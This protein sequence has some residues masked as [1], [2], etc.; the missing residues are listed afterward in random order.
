MSDVIE[1]NKEITNANLD[2]F[3]SDGK[4]EENTISSSQRRLWIFDK[5]NPND[6]VIYN[7]P[8]S[9]KV[10][11]E[12][13]LERLKV[14]F[15]FLL[16]KHPL[17]RASIQENECDPFMILNNQFLPSY[18]QGTVSSLEEFLEIAKRELNEPFDLNQPPLIRLSVFQQSEDTYYI[19][20]IIHH[21]VAD[22][23]SISII[24]DT[25]FQ[26][27]LN[28]L[29]NQSLSEVDILPDMTYFQYIEQQKAI[30]FS[31]KYKSSE[32]FWISYL[33][34]APTKTDFPWDR[35][36]E[37]LQ[38]Y[39]GSLHNFYLSQHVADKVARFCSHHKVTPYTFFLSL[40]YVLLFRYSQQDK[41]VVATQSAN[42]NGRLYHATVGFFVNTLPICQ[43][44]KQEDKFLDFLAKIK[45][46]LIEAYK[47]QHVEF[48]RILELCKVDRTES[49]KPLCQTEFV[50]QNVR[51]CDEALKDWNI[52]NI[53]VPTD[54]AKYDLSFSVFPI[55]KTYQIVIEY[56]KELLECSTIKRL[57]NNFETLVRS[58]VSFPDIAIKDI[59][60]I[61]KSEKDQLARM[62]KGKQVDFSNRNLTS[63]YSDFA[64][65]D[66]SAI[67]SVFNKKSTSYSEILSSSS[68]LANFLDN[69]DVKK[70]DRVII[71]LS[72]GTLLLQAILACLMRLIIFIPINPDD[73]LENNLENILQGDPVVI[74]TDNNYFNKLKELNELDSFEIVNI[75]DVNITNTFSNF[76]K[77]IIRQP[78]DGDIA[79]IM[80]TSGSTG[81]PKGAM[82]T[83]KGMLNHLLSKIEILKLKKSDVVGQIAV[84]SFDVFIWQS[85]VGGLVGAKT[86]ILT[87]YQA[88]DPRPLFNA[89]KQYEITILETVPA[90][91][92]ILAS[93]ISRDISLVDSVQ[94]LR[95]LMSNGESISKKQVNIWFDYLPNINFINAYGPTEC[96]DDVLH[97]SITNKDQFQ[98]MFMPI[99]RPIQNV[100][101]YILDPQKRMLPIN[102]PGELYIAGI[103]VGKG[104]FR[105]Q[106]R[107]ASSFTPIPS[108]ISKYN[109][110]YKTGDIVKVDKEGI[111]HFI[112]RNDYEVKIRGARIDL[113]KIESI[114]M[115]HDNI[116]DAVVVKVNDSKSKLD[117]LVAYLIARDN[118][119]P[120]SKM[121]LIHCEKFLP[122]K[123]LPNGIVFLD[124]FP[125]LSN[126]KVDRK[127]LPEPH[128]ILSGA[129][130]DYV[131]PRNTREKQ[132]A[133][134][135]QSLLGVEK[136]G[137]DD[138]FFMLGGHSLL[139]IE[140]VREI[141]KILSEQIELAYFFENPSIRSL[142]DNLQ[143]FKKLEENRENE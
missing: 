50:M 69:K 137:I 125:V 120:T 23:W 25:L 48:D 68:V 37:N 58:I 1:H 95:C 85:L 31:D 29:N 117:M 136:I 91:L 103:P 123:M 66:P 24:V 100:E 83:H 128:T 46:N 139:A 67:F 115:M 78:E 16:Q 19:L 89:V 4:V 96:S 111:F 131:P 64:L 71:Y 73:K 82:V 44:I 106:V 138:N 118:P 21:I 45:R 74:L 77:E 33:K 72:R 17:L 101:L 84:Q 11:V 129:T 92:V 20:M 55:K 41:I 134:V 34:D 121:M 122:K 10:G 105:D 27:Y 88:W 119:A 36:V 126:G 142:L 39:D 127:S 49:H 5:C 40:Y 109:L 132:I 28:L 140:L 52:E 62:A 57:A 59:D 13:D 6:R 114:L 53:V 116:V 81:K 93:E 2:L 87:G 141:N 56:S 98:K 143:K 9:F 60:F 26:Y 12:L 80:Y 43:E 70:Q 35:D 112:G 108:E 107:T 104:Y 124:N 113:N 135:W 42:R 90:H 97:H 61:S 38:S 18:K 7:M 110:A 130:K 15:C 32:Q 63:I 30:K 22:S 102:V 99:G 8:V 79:Y 76:S 75:S 86:I 65:E 133:A 47:H 94:S 51:E 3:K 14:A 54:F